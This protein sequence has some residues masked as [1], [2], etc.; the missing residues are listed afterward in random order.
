MVVSWLVYLVIRDSQPPRFDGSAIRPALDKEGF[1]RIMAW[2]RRNGA[3]RA[4][5]RNFQLQLSSLVGQDRALT[6][7]V[8]ERCTFLHPDRF[9]AERCEFVDGQ[10]MVGQ[11][12][13]LVETSTS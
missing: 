11:P 2:R 9:I 13:D 10:E 6:D 4:Y 7:V 12:D 3:A 1:D 5:I 8:F